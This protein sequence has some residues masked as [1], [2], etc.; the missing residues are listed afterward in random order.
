MQ[1]SPSLF[2]AVAVLA[3]VCRLPGA[4]A[5]ATAGVGA[6]FPFMP[7]W[8]VATTSTRKRWSRTVRSRPPRNEDAMIPGVTCRLPTDSPTTAPTAA[9]SA[10]PTAAPTLQGASG[11]KKGG[12]STAKS[13]KTAKSSKSSKGKKG[14]SDDDDLPLCPSVSDGTDS[15]TTITVTITP[16]TTSSPTP[17]VA[18]TA[19]PT[20][21]TST[22]APP[23]TDEIPI[24]AVQ[25]TGGATTT[26][27]TTP[28]SGSSPGSSG[29]Q[30]GGH[31]V[32]QQPG[33]GGSGT[34]AETTTVVSSTNSGVSGVTTT[35]STF[36]QED[37]GGTGAAQG[38]GDGGSAA[39]QA[40]VMFGAAGVVLVIGAVVIRQMRKSSLASAA[41]DGAE[42][43]ENKD[44]QDDKTLTM[45]AVGLASPHRGTMSPNS[46]DVDDYLHVSETGDYDMPENTY[47][48]PLPQH[49]YETPTP[50]PSVMYDEPTSS[51]PD[52]D[53]AA[54]GSI[55]AVGAAA[56]SNAARPRSTRPARPTRRGVRPPQARYD[57]AGSGSGAGSPADGTHHYADID[58]ITPPR[59]T[60]AVGA[61]SVVTSPP[62]PLHARGET[63][64]RRDSPP[65]PLF[66]PYYAQCV[67]E[68]GRTTPSGTVEGYDSMP[69]GHRRSS[70]DT[71]TY[72][73]D[74]RRGSLCA[75][76]QYEQPNGPVYTPVAPEHTPAFVGTPPRCVGDGTVTG[77]AIRPM[78][79]SV[80]S[81]A[82]S[83]GPLPVQGR[84]GMYDSV[85][86]HSTDD[87]RSSLAPS[88]TGGTPV[89]H[90]FA[91]E[92]PS[93]RKM[94]LPC[95]PDYEYDAIVFGGTHGEDTTGYNTS[96]G[97]YAGFDTLAAS[98]AGD[99][100]YYTTA[101]HSD[102]ED[103]C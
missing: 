37:T 55:G 52:Y 100:D 44:G 4:D 91:A 88:V 67:S 29:G 3:C 94:S 45:N 68:T 13:A 59:R 50:Q 33:G 47:D 77:M 97:Y 31:I 72:E 46:T 62:P 8:G 63:V 92:S 69:D 78:S 74:S 93:P 90:P 38:G 71:L 22:I 16:S 26:S 7:T 85:I 42:A 60:G 86:D 57:Q 103:A 14:S 70:V 102:D 98:A 84:P 12:G 56:A 20:A 73:H 53:T 15:T 76:V 96:T 87:D 5:H 81:T 30:G 39:I 1:Y 18:P 28:A 83:S 40:G 99:D 24:T 54:P 9:P 58:P 6:W 48:T 17:S 23:P 82:S 19:P 36:D 49:D 41:K 65:S 95:D 80:S 27:G 64:R 61:S 10:Q 11:G 35:L 79:R 25:P 101:Q 32:A 43:G 75:A 2:V 89:R 51:L 21:S 34:V 66:N